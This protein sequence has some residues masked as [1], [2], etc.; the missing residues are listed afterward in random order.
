MIKKYLNIVL[1]GARLSIVS[2]LVA[3]PTRWY[4][5]SILPRVIFQTLFFSLL[6]G[7]LGGERL[8]DYAFFGNTLGVMINACIVGTTGVVAEERSW[9]MLPILSVAP[10]GKEF[11]LIGRSIGNTALALLNV[12]VMIVFF[13]FSLVPM[14]PISFF[15]LLPIML[16]T[17]ASVTGLGILIGSI[18][19]NFRNVNIM[20]NLV[21]YFI[22][23]FSGVNFPLSNLPPIIQMFSHVLP[24]T[25]GLAASRLIIMGYP[26]S[27]IILKY[28]LG[29]VMLSVLYLG[30]GMQIFRRQLASGRFSGRLE[31]M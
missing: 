30:L 8:R 3:T 17:S 9:G 1:I 22:L 10:V 15:L 11:S 21:A 2:T 5:L 18:G 25:N 23:V 7:Y 24:F 19:L 4:L 6:S 14:K 31:I 27:P 16:I 13:S 20:A 29:E 28:L 26:F 12:T